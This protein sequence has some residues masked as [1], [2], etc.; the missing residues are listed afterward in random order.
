MTFYVRDLLTAIRHCRNHVC[1]QCKCI[2]ITKIYIYTSDI[3][4]EGLILSVI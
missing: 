3:E 4:Q 1:I 2:S